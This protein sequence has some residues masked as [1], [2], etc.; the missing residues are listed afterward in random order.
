MLWVLKRTVSMRRVIR[1]P[2]TMLEMMGKNIY[3]QFWA[4]NL[5]KSFSFHEL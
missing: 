4:I 3:L 1:A 5:V 2:K